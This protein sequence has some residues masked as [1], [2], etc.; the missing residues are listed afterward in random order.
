MILIAQDNVTSKWWNCHSNMYFWDSKNYTV[1]TKIC[2][3]VPWQA[4]NSFLF[5]T[6]SPMFLGRE[7]NMACWLCKIQSANMRTSGHNSVTPEISG[8]FAQVI[9]SRTGFNVIWGLHNLSS[10]E[11]SL[12]SMSC[13]PR[14]AMLKGTR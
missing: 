6:S 5:S 4:T 14:K 2:C 10:S 3:S 11:I 9:Y 8:V 1:F 7:I 13:W 12:I